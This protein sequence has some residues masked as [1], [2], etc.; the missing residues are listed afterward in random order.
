VNVD[1]PAFHPPPSRIVVVETVYHQEHGSEPVAAGRPFS[2]FL[3]TAEQ[4]FGPRRLKVG[5]EW[6]PIETGWLSENVGMLYLRNEGEGLAASRPGEP[7][8]E[9][10]ARIIE[11][12]LLVDLNSPDADL[13]MHDPASLPVVVIPFGQIRP[14][15]S[16]R[17]EP[18]NL[19]L[20]RVR[21]ETGECRLTVH[22]FPG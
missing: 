9:E 4:P 13:T 7:S 3:S 21:C 19:P 15:E 8:E 12:G 14:G 17:E 2:R 18:R 16:R 20:F 10:P 6:Q 22:A 1:E 5:C 11:L